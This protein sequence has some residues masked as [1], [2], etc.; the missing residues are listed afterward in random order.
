MKPVALLLGLLAPLTI[1]S[2]SQA[3]IFNDPFAEYA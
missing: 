1:C 3:Q 2:V